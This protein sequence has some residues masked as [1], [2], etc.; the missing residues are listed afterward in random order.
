MH[1]YND[2][3]FICVE[4]SCMLIFVYQVFNCCADIRKN[5]CR[6]YTQEARTMHCTPTLHEEKEEKG[7]AESDGIR[8]L[9][10][11]LSTFELLTKIRTLGNVVKYS[12]SM[13]I[14]IR[15]LGKWIRVLY[16]HYW[17]V[18]KPAD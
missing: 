5:V 11:M 15:Y 2:M 12:K 16:V 18:A 8:C 17:Y 13:Y 6:L 10:T 3:R 9:S 1:V 14:M 4:L 7:L